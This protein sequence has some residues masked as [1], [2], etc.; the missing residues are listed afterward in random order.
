MNY[1]Y[2]I[3]YAVL[4][5][6]DEN[7]MTFGFV[8]SKCYIIEDSTRYLADGSSIKYHQVVFPYTNI[9]DFRQK[10]YYDYHT[11]DIGCRNVPGYD[12]EG[13]LYNASIAMKLFDNYNDAKAEAN[14][15]N[16]ILLKKSI[17]ELP[18]S[19]PNYEKEKE[20]INFIFS[21]NMTTCRKFEELIQKQ[22]SDMN[23]SNEKLILIN[24]RQ[25][26]NSFNRR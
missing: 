11:Q 24:K 1:N 23:I 20:K 16:Q 4:E 8:A 22:T 21:L 13:N 15:H 17:S 25:K 7:N 10:V 18:W 14:L 3:K 5:L 9:V 6:I 26:N 2:P 12:L 19:H